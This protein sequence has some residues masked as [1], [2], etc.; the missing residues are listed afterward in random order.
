[1]NN[2]FPQPL[3]WLVELGLLRVMLLGVIFTYFIKDIRFSN[4]F[5]LKNRASLKNS[6]GVMAFSM[7]VFALVGSPVSTLVRTFRTD[8][9]DWRPQ[10]VAGVTALKEETDHE[11]AQEFFSRAR[12]FSHAKQE[13][14]YLEALAWYDVDPD[15]SVEILKTMLEGESFPYSDFV[16]TLSRKASLYKYLPIIFKDKYHAY[17]LFYKNI[18]EDEFIANMHKLY[19][20]DNAFA[21]FTPLEQADLLKRWCSSRDADFV[22]TKSVAAAK[23]NPWAFESLAMSRLGGF[24]QAVERVLSNMEEPA[25]PQLKVPQS[26]EELFDLRCAFA[27]TGDALAGLALVEF[28]K[29]SDQVDEIEEVMAFLEK[30]SQDLPYLVYQRSKQ[31]YKEGRAVEA[32]NNVYPL[33]ENYLN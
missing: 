11:A 13:I 28:F 23:E 25:I 33:L 14:P 30:K 15:Q 5:N 8:R 3:V 32:W 22:L 29:E 31:L 16:Y 27:Q 24:D 7:I 4:L 9:Y 17:Y 26:K 6:F 19:E 2:N 1:V 20:E 18:S 21:N 12:Y 10:L